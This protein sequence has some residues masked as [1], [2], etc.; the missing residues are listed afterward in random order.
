MIKYLV[1]DACGACANGLEAC[2]GPN[3][4]ILMC[5]FHVQKNVKEYLKSVCEKL[6][7]EVVED[8]S[9]MHFC[10]SELEFI[11]AKFNIYQKWEAK[12]LN[13]FKEYF[14]K[15]WVKNKFNKWQIYHSPNGFATT[16]NPCESFNKYIKLKFTNHESFSLLQ[17]IKII[18]ED[19]IPYYSTNSSNKSIMRYRSAD[20]KIKQQS[21]VLKPDQFH[22]PIFF[23]ISDFIY[24]F[25]ESSIYKIDIES[26]TCTCRWHKAYGSCKHIYR[27]LLTII[28]M[29]YHL[30][31]SNNF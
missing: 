10:R 22:Q 24:F 13:E 7:S 5:Y 30:I 4:V 20:A 23:N 26:K 9:Y 18:C 29:I 15:Q 28:K 8:V 19:L 2:F 3:I 25:G 16:N 11:I 17:L 31:K 14:E 6:R 21:L 1:Q 12:G 27:Y